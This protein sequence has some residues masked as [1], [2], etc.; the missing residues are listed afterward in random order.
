MSPEFVAGLAVGEGY[1]GIAVRKYR[2]T[3]RHGITMMPA[4]SMGMND[5]DT[6]EAVS[7]YLKSIE[8]AHWVFR[9]KTKRFAQINVH[10]LRRLSRLLPWMMPYLIGDKKKCADNLAAY[11]AYRLSLPHQSPVT[12]RDL[13]FVRVARSLNGGQGAGRTADIDALSKTLRDYM[14]ERY[15]SGSRYSPYSRES[16]RARQK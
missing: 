4:F 9:H 6:I 14:S 8:M 15:E 5:V 7:D 16:V 2:E 1:F 3:S 13:D 12:E 10:G 11:V